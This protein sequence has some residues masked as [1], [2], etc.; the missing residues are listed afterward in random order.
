MSYEEKDVEETFNEFY[1]EGSTAWATF[2]DEAQID[3]DFYLG[4]QYTSSEKI[5]LN[6]EKRHSLVYN[7]IQ[8]VINML[9]GYQ[10]KHRLSSIVTPV[11]NSDQKTADQLSQ[12]LLYVMQSADGYQ[13]I[14]DSFGGALK[15]GINLMSIW[16]NYTDDPIN[17][18]ICLTRE[19]FKSFIIDPYFTKLDLSDA[20]YI[21]RRKLLSEDQAIALLPK[22]K[23]KI[24]ELSEHGWE[25]DNKFSW[26]P[27]QRIFGG[28]KMMAYDE[29][30]QQGWKSI[31][32]L[33][34]TE[35]GE[36]VDYED[37]SK[38]YLEELKITYPQ[39]EIIKKQKAYVTRKILVNNQFIEE[40]ENPD[41]INEYPFVAVVANFEQESTNWALRIQ[42]KVRALRDPQIESNTRRNVMVDIIRS[43]LNSGWIATEGAVVNK[44]SLFQTSQGKVVWRSADALPG[45]L[46]RIQAAQIPPSMFALTELFDKDLMEIAGVNDAA[47]GQSDM[48]ESGVLAMLRQGAS[49]VNNQ[50][51]FDN[52]RFSQKIMSK[53]ILKQIQT[54]TPS[55][56][57]RII[58]DKPTDQFYN[59]KFSK[60]DCV[61]QE[62]ILTD[63]QRQMFFRQL[64]D[65]KQLGEP[66]P[67]MML[68]KAAPLQGKNELILEIEAYQEQQQQAAQ[69]QA[70]ERQALLQSQAE[71]NTSKSISAIAS[72]K[73]NYTRAIANMGLEDSRASSAVEDRANASLTRIKAIKELQSLDDDRLIKYLSVIRIMENNFK[74][75]EKAI[76]SDNISIVDRMT[77]E[78]PE[79]QALPLQNN[80]DVNINQMEVLN[81]QI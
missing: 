64:V 17:G 51:L 75:Q 3:L 15:T 43:Q 14:S 27:Y 59:K 11:E 80:A 23:K 47:F 24:K 38:E 2:F 70:E 25:R 42:S 69:G 26:L 68:I 58:N 6:G 60:Y 8:R 76:K 48:Q 79:S 39:L 72:A 74:E 18:D 73:E 81:G 67:P 49:L 62:G 12:C 21:I 56:I 34:D 13:T 71:Y 35:T 46:E 7:R 65:L 44:D 36:F 16:M 32:V 1:E 33:V 5:A 50:D 61:V 29:L 57:E 20:S 10:R 30:W 19:S 9:T 4:A 63:T 66:I 52:L 37:G 28:Q 40:E 77:E 78:I 55:K 41:G 31:D 22:H 53:K 45:S 54:W